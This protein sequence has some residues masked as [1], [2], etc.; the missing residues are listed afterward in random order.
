M[1]VGNR[2]KLQ[3]E[4][5]QL[6]LLDLTSLEP[7]LE[8]LDLPAQT[9]KL[10]RRLLMTLLRQIVD[11]LRPAPL[12]RGNLFVHPPPL[13]RRDRSFLQLRQCFLK[14]AMLNPDDPIPAPRRRQLILEA[15]QLHSR[16]RETRSAFLEE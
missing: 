4:L 9:V 13:V 1:F 10:P 8:L 12:P 5:R 6:D 16:R 3:L 14:S 15:Q 7:P 11:P 2:N